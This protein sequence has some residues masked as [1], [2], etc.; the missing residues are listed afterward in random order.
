[1]VEISLVFKGIG[2][3]SEV[4]KM[5]GVFDD[6]ETVT[7]FKKLDDVASWA[8]M[9]EVFGCIGVMNDVV[10]WLMRGVAI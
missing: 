10:D 4:A 5:W 2:W 1:M 8:F 9:D 7:L 6:E 3:N